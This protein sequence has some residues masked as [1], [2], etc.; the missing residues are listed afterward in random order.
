MTSEYIFDQQPTPTRADSAAVLIN[1]WRA[2][3]T[4]RQT[5]FTRDMIDAVWGTELVDGEVSFA[6]F[7]S[8]DGRDLFA[9]KQ[10]TSKAVYDTFLSGRGLGGAKAFRAANPDVEF[11]HD[12]FAV[13]HSA[14]TPAR[15]HLGLRGDIGL[16]ITPDPNGWTVHP[17]D[18]VPLPHPTRFTLLRGIERPV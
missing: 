17:F 5:R 12:W 13:D 9:Y 6:L 2:P 1:L 16:T 14:E 18:G 10:W 15:L 11:W 4:E 3:D 8:D 7:R